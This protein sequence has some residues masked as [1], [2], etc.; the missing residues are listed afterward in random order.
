MKKAVK[1]A[2][3]RVM[4]EALTARIL[5]ETR[6]QL[7]RDGYAKLRIEKVAAAVGCGKSTI[8]RRWPDK[9]VI[10]AEAIAHN[11]SAPEDVD[12]GNVVDDLALF[13]HQQSGRMNRDRKP[14]SGVWSAMFEDD[15]RSHLWE[16]NFSL[17]REVGRAIVA[18]GIAAG[19]IAADT[20]P[21]LLLD[22]ISGFAIY[23][24]AFRDI[25]IDLEAERVIVARLC[26]L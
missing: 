26:G 11:L 13:A 20:D 18:R 8:Y 14:S 9:G 12:T 15:V 17:R 10:V 19:Q 24:Q 3:G 5:E 22:A 21:D 16:L 4:D 23:R 1:P 2:R 6:A 7:A 25:P